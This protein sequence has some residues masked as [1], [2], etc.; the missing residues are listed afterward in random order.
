MSTTKK[1]NKKFKL[2]DNFKE[3]LYKPTVD[4]PNLN[5]IKD[6]KELFNSNLE[7]LNILQQ[8]TNSKSFLYPIYDDEKFQVKIASK[9]EFNDFSYKAEVKNVQEEAEKICSKSFE[10]SPHQQF[11]KNFLS[12]NTPYNSILLYHGLGTGKTCSAIGVAEET[13]SYLTQMNISQRIIIVASPNVQENFKIQLFDERKLNFKNNS[14]NIDNCAGKNFLKEIN[15]ISNK[16]ITKD[17]VIKHVKNVINN[18]YLFMGYIEFAN[19]IIKNS[20]K[21][22]LESSDS[23]EREKI[24]SGKLQSLFNNRL[25]IIDE[26]QNVRIDSNDN[27]VVAQELMKLVKNTDNMKL[28]LLSATP[29]YNSYK[30]II[31]LLNLMN[32][33]DNKVPIAISD[34]F[35]KNGNFLIDKTNNIEIGK[36]L[37][38]RKANGY[39]SYVRGE[40]PYSFPYRI[41]PYQFEPDKTIKSITYPKFQLN[42]KE[43]VE[44]IKHLSIY[45]NKIG[46]Y[47]NKAYDFIIKSIKELKDDS[48]SKIGFD[49]LDTFGYNILQKLIE[50]LIFAY[51]NDQLESI[52]QEGGTDSDKSIEFGSELSELPEVNG[53]QSI[54][55][56]NESEED[57]QESEQEPQEEEIELDIEPEEDDKDSP[58]EEIEAEQ[59]V[60]VEPE[61]KEVELED[62]GVEQPQEVIN[63]SDE[64]ELFEPPQE[65][66]E[67][68]ENT[69]KVDSKELVGKNGLNNIIKYKTS[70]SPPSRY[71]FEFIDK[72]YDNIFAYDKIENYSSKIKSILDSILY[73]EGIVLIYSQFIDGGLIP[74]ALALESIG[75]T[76]YGATKSLFKTPP[77]EKLDVNTYLPKSSVENSKF[78]AAKYTMITGDKTITP[79]YATDLK[80]ATNESNKNGEDIKVILISQAGSEGID[81]KCI[82]QVHILD[83][84]YNMNRIEQIIGRGVRTC[85]HS[86][87]PFKDRNVSIYLHGILLDNDKESVDLYLYR[88]AES[89]SIKIGEV[90]RV[91]KQIAID[92]ILN[93][94]QQ[95]FN[96]NNMNQTVKLELSNKKIIDYKVGDKPYS[97]I[98]DYMESCTYDCANEEK[99][100]QLNVDNSTYND[101]FLV[102]NNEYIISILKNLFKQNFF[103]YKQDLIDRINSYK[104]YSNEQIFSA[105]TQLIENK[106]Q[107]LTD[108][109]N[110]IGHLLNIEDIYF[111]QPTEISYTKE[112]MYYKSKPLVKKNDSINYKIPEKFKKI[113]LKENKKKLKLIKDDESKDDDNSNPIEKD[114]LKTEKAKKEELVTKILFNKTETEKLINQ[115]ENNYNLAYNKQLLVRGEDNYYKAASII[116]EH[117]ESKI[118]KELL[119]QFIFDHL[120][121]ILNYNQNFNLINYLYFTKKERELTLFEQKL[122]DYYDSN[123]IQKDSIKALIFNDFGG[124]KLLVYNSKYNTWEEGKSELVELENKLKD[125][126]IKK[127]D[128]NLIL[129]F[130]GT[131]KNEINVYKVKQMDK[132][133]NKGARCDQSGKADALN[134]L[135]SI[136]GENEYNVANTK[137]YNQTFICII[138]EL[139]LRYYNSIKKNGK[140]WFL[141]PEIAIINEIEKIQL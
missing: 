58:K 63:Q 72:K 29:M 5:T 85:S 23:K 70:S 107:F 4:I 109:F 51:P 34:V 18:S 117:L 19:Y 2:V 113:D 68:I 98:C 97:S 60:D 30:E 103:Y 84:W 75:F 35:D 118:E 22:I 17:Q 66:R 6:N 99:L 32:I 39:I 129:G 26:I 94:E 88:I 64:E 10:L 31:W 43:I 115:L 121:E 134:I 95:I 80:A 8:K 91:L 102:T 53:T 56:P 122:I 128:Y 111:F 41:W 135:N 104:K 101:K 71:D 16:N 132:K 140:V 42:D 73:S 27:K 79:N 13:R 9:K 131:F 7:L 108:K 37:L 96:E 110:N 123:I 120:I 100:N 49:E 87:L 47:Q 125:L 127:E 139:Y 76:R 21:N 77:V 112:D 138:Q 105:L 15:S 14:W 93:Q 3:Y 83:P 124:L 74:L 126:I 114:D 61:E 48:K 133:R 130:I 137:K 59:E 106:N 20:T 25:V 57:P 89:K 38:M 67:E 45:I 44:P 28:L 1:I 55:E 92:C 116:I 52:S 11:I 50:C 69:I 46:K 82:R 119:L 78:K 65:P 136:I 90:S 12:S 81:F 24:I 40:N 141:K 36:Q 54:Q 86:S 33:N 62:K